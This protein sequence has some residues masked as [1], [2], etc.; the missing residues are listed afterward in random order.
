M[1][2]EFDIQKLKQ[3]LNNQ[4]VRKRLAYENPLW[5]SLIYLRHHIPY[6]LAPFHKEMGY[7]LVNPSYQFIVMMAFRESGKSTI[8]NMANV[9]WS[10][11]GKPQKKFPVIVSKT[12]DQ[13]SNHFANLK[14]E[15][16]TNELLRSDFGPFTDNETDW[17]KKTSLELIYHGSKIMSVSLEQSIR[18]L[19]YG[20]IRPDLIIADDIEDVSMAQDDIT[21][22]RAWQRL[23]SEIM[24]LGSTGTKIVILGNLICPDS[25]MMRLKEYIE[26][27]RIKGI[28]RAYPLLDDKRRILWLD[29][30][31]DLPHIVEMKRSF[32]DSVWTREFLLKILGWEHGRDSDDE[33][34]ARISASGDQRRQEPEKIT[35]QKPLVTQMKPYAISVPIDKPRRGFSTDEEVD[36]QRYYGNVDIEEPMRTAKEIFDFE[37]SLFSRWDLI[38][39]DH[40]LNAT[41]QEE[42]EAKMAQ[43]EKEC[44]VEFKFG[45]SSPS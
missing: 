2:P 35:Y 17:K 36:Y 19:K 43:A 8:M 39:K 18:G 5:F 42:Y 13:A 7:L 27:G 40:M 23:M 30:F 14:N 1:S 38:I 33:V 11:L 21:R 41:P 22:D 6:P 16:L 3:A 4:D 25:I 24:P 9:L 31:I 32:T 45:S 44:E 12:Q 34:H 20:K 37:T 28:F 10:V 15:L 26:A 29:R